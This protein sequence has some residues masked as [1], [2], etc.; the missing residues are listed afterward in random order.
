MRAAISFAAAALAL[1]LSAPFARAQTAV[2]EA[3]DAGTPDDA[4]T[5]VPAAAPTAARIPIVGYELGGTRVDPDDKLQALLQSVSA[6]GDPFVEAGPSDKIGRPFGTV[7]RVVQAMDAFGY[8]AAVTTRPAPGGV[9]VAVTLLPYE[10]LRYVFVT[11][12]RRIQQDEIQRRITIRPGQTMPPPGPERA[13]VLE[14]ERE[15]VI[16]FLRSRGYFEAN[17]GLDARPG[18]VAGAL[19]LYVNVRLGPAYPLGP[20]TF[21][22]NHAISTS[23]LDPMFRHAD[24]LTLWNTPVPFTQKQLREDMD[25]V[26][27]RYR[28]L[29]YAGVR[30]TTDFSV[31][32]GVDRG[33]KNVRIGIAINERKRIV[34]A[35]EGNASESNAALTDE[36]TL[37][38]R[39]SYDDYEVGAS[40]DAIQRHYQQAGHLLARV[41]WR[42]ERLSANEERIVFSIDE[43]PT[44]KVRAV[45]F[46]GARAIP[47]S[48]LAE[49]VSVRPYPFLG[50]GSGGYATGR[51][52]Q[53]DVERL[54]GHYRGKGFIDVKARVDAA[55]SP[56]A[57]GALGAVAAAA[58]TSSRDGGDLYVRFTIDEGP[59]L[60]LVSETFRSADDTPLPYDPRFL[61]DSVALRPGA[62]YAPPAV[63][64]DAK[65]LARLFGD[66][67]FPLARVSPDV[68]RKG[69]AVALTWTV[70]LGPRMALG[71]IFVRGNFV[72]RPRTILQ[73]IRL[74]PGQPLSTTAVERSQRDIGFLQLFNNASPISFPGKDDKR[75][76]AAPGAPAPPQVTPM[77]VEVEERYEQYSVIHI[78]AGASTDQ[79]PPDS[80]FPFGVY[81]RAGY[82]NRDLGGFGWTLNSG[83]TYGTAILRGNIAFLDRR[84]LGTLFR[85]DASF[86]Y[87]SQATVRLGDIHSGGGSIGFSREM[88]PGVDAGIHY[89]L[90]N[91]THTEP[92]LRQAGPDE[93]TQ[94]V[95]L[96]TTVG[97]LSANVEW[98]RMD[99]RLLPTRG[100]R[101]DAIAE[102]ALPALSLPLRPFPFAIGDDTFLKVGVHSLSVIPLGRRIYLRYGFRY[103]QGFP[104][105]GAS[106]LPKVE[107]YFAGGDTTIRGYQ[108]DRARVEVVE[109]PLIPIDPRNP[110]AGG[111]YAVE[112]RPLGGNLRIIQNIDLQIPIAPP[113][114]GAVFMD[115]GVVADSLYGLTL[116]Q[117]R[118][119]IGVSPLLIRLPIGDVSLAWGWPLN[120]GPGDTR[121]GVLHV[122]VGLM[123]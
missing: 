70:T 14:R 100:F 62:A 57:L 31:Q 91:T 16:D 5:S 119:G 102:L 97:S 48:V 40:A 74:K 32:K 77:L 118:H 121:I 4:A 58:E 92:L 38:S 3:V 26:A 59:R 19:D 81:L 44:L 11:G 109:Q 83:L 30:V 17:V 111:L 95:T 63:Q 78:G 12:N 101:I 89:N 72:T 10:R 24:W 43:G 2:D 56:A 114:Y 51:Q 88:Y 1:M 115:S 8:R 9:T 103:D 123:F 20:I 112:Y 46:A 113:W 69:E 49:V 52:L 107:R 39:G 82:D 122:N 60:R 93:N 53:Q 27:K 68:D 41:D 50:I 61:L 7:P 54:I 96:G 110:S 85:L 87:L 42:R 25:A 37:F 71:P 76:Q 55:T 6:I 35:F 64:A 94:N 28:A 105:G 104:L 116:T 15:L 79:K 23:D 45:E 99:N 80:S 13:I 90:R 21:T 66:A 34:V 106:L 120:P 117:F 108:L 98:L 75:A 36:L 84:F 22:G 86:T 47:P 73:Q 67:G 33:A 18:T 65:R 29:G